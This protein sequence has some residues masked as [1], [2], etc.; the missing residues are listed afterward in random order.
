MSTADG[1]LKEVREITFSKETY[2]R[3]KEIC[4]ETKSDLD[5]II[6]QAI[7]HYYEFHLPDIKELRRNMQGENAVV[8]GHS[9]IP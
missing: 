7:N 6:D 8:N 1:D 9:D 4:H 3:A 5:F 2:E